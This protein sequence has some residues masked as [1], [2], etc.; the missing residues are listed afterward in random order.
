MIRITV[1]SSILVMV[2]LLIRKCFYYHIT[3]RLQYA[4]WLSVPLYLI[5]APFLCIEIPVHG[6]QELYWIMESGNRRD[7]K[8][9]QHITGNKQNENIGIQVNKQEHNK[10]NNINTQNK[11]TSI[12]PQAS[13]K[14]NIVK[15][16]FIKISKIVYFIVSIGIIICILLK[17]CIFISR[18]YKE[19][20]YYKTDSRTGLKVYIWEGAST[21]FL[22]GR[23]VYISPVIV[24]DTQCLQYILLHEYCHWKHGDLLW[25]IVK[26]GIIAFLWYNPL[27]WAASYY[28]ECDC[29]LACDE[30]VIKIAGQ[31]KVLQYGDVLLYL[32]LKKANKDIIIQSMAGRSS[33]M[34]KER[35]SYIIL[36]K[37]NKRI[38]ILAVILIAVIVFAGLFVSFTDSP[39]AMQKASVLSGG[40]TKDNVK[41]ADSIENKTEVME[42]NYYNCMKTDGTYIYY[43]LNNKLV[44]TCIKTG[45]NK[46]IAE[47][48]RNSF[49]RLG[50]IA[51]N[52]LYYTKVGSPSV[53]GRISLSS[54]SDEIIY[55]EESGNS[56]GFGWPHIGNDGTVYCEE[57]IGTVQKCHMYKFNNGEGIWETCSNSLFMKKAEE[58]EEKLNADLFSDYI[59]A[60]ENNIMLFYNPSGIFI[61]NKD[62]KQLD[63]IEGTFFNIML[64]DKGVVYT[65]EAYNIYLYSYNEPY[66]SNI[67]FKPDSIRAYFNYA[68]Y[69][70]NG[71]Y[72]I[73]KNKDNK[74]ILA[75][76]SWN[77]GIKILHTF[78]SKEELKG[79]GVSAFGS[80]CA[81]LIDGKFEFIEF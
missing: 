77:G 37:K 33:N 15:Y 43:P 11:I 20:K 60:V 71:L 49:F 48:G 64:A 53:I 25:V 17:N 21:P 7:L 29:E 18:C 61:Y 62:G 63:K 57:K 35:I 80:G 28:E 56:W 23:S 45:E 73:Y 13:G 58:T 52:Y 6:G 14:G 66:N 8:Q 78:S 4:L 67:I 1:L 32:A 40:N 59:Q 3:R 22:L 51:E 69:D 68:V 46:E 30:A 65:D 39:Q 5:L 2:V 47:A 70:Q 38:T 54:L 42:N 36:E 76:L 41:K 81:F 26:Y 24:Q 50:D 75:R 10:V 55:R 19:R 31:D 79:L 34:L 16:W 72:G 44:R 9:E 27:I 74:Y 12:K